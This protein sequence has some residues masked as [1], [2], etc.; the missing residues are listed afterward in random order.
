MDSSEYRI[1]TG[2]QVNDDSCEVIEA[3]YVSG[4]L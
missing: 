2:V 3:L 1:T 4:D